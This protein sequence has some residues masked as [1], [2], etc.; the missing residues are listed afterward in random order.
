MYKRVLTFLGGVLLMCA[1]LTAPAGAGSLSPLPLKDPAET[2]HRFYQNPQTI[3]NI[4]DP[5][6]LPVEGKYHI[7]ATSASVGFY[8]WSSDDLKTFGGKK[9]ALQR[10]AWATGDYWAPE[11]YAYNGK[12]V[13]LFSARRASDKSLRIGIAVADKPEGP[14]KDPLDAPLFDPGYAVIDASL[15][16]DDDGAPY[17]YYSRD[18]SENV[19]G[20]FHESHIYVV[21]LSPDLLSTVGEPVK[22]TSPDQAWELGSGDYRWNEGPVVVKHDNKYY[23]YYS[24]NYFSAKEYGVGVAV[25]ESPEGPFVKSESNPLLTYVEEKGEVIVSGPGHN[26]FFT[27]GDELFTAYHTH[28]YPSAPTGNR[29]LNYD[30]AGFHA[31]GTAYINGPTQFTQ[32]L[33]YAMLDVKNIAPLA[34]LTFEGKNGEMLTD[35]DYCVSPASAEYV[36]RGT[37]AELSFD[38]PAKADTV[39]LYPG[40][41]AYAK[42]TLTINGTYETPVDMT[43]YAG[44]PGGCQ[45]ISFEA[46]EINS[47]QLVLDVETSLGEIIVLGNN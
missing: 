40:P 33:P 11:V 18:C 7:F 31:D 37:K 42:G 4:G 21:K 23:L 36:F 29:Q 17:L 6:I 24:A 38:K 16:V 10:V 44:I 32:L 30:R 20:F 26:S 47:V 39:I 45:I 43:S 3:N 5:F 27:V 35:G 19:V 46:M 15:F 9:K 25:A 34:K 41:E 28:T 2:V 22:L 1:I 8:T 12:Y 13:M 14:Y